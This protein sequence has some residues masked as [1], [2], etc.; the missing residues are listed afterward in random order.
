[1]F[2]WNISFFVTVTKPEKVIQAAEN[3]IQDA[4]RTIQAGASTA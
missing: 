2:A 1:M 3:L 4:G